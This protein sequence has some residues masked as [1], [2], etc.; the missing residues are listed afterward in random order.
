L[1]VHVVNTSGIYMDPKK[2]HAVQAML[3]PK[4]VK[5]VQ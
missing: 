1:L 3:P 5:Q 2:I 4:N